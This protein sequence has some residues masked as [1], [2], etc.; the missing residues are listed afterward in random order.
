MQRLA[1]VFLLAIATL[2][3]SAAEEKK[4]IP[5]S[6]TDR[7][8]FETKVR[9]L[10]F[11]NCQKCHSTRAKKR[12]GGL[13]LDSREAVLQG[14]DSGS[15]AVPGD[16]EKS[17]LIQAIRYRNAQLQMPPSSWKE[18]KLDP[19]VIRIVVADSRNIWIDLVLLHDRNRIW[20]LTSLPNASPS[21][22]SCTQLLGFL[23]MQECH[24]FS[25]LQSW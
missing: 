11:E 19:T 17:L 18:L 5:L 13:L 14:G 12:K 9:P 23:E 3:A 20:Y 10:L 8:F 16:V 1:L 6:P 24:A 7:D 4:P 22:G 21:P 15:A 2:R 25:L